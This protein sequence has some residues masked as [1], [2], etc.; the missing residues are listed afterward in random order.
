MTTFGLDYSGTVPSL[1]SMLSAG[2]EFVVRYIGY[3]S[4]FDDTN[5][6]TPQGKCLTKTEAQL[7][8]E[9]GISV[10]SNFEWYA[11]RP[12]EGFLAGISDAQEA[13]KIHLGCGGPPDAPIYFSVD[14]NSNGYDAVDYF[15]GVVSA[16]GI[17][18]VG[19]YGPYTVMQVFVGNGGLASFYWQT[20][21]WSGGQWFPNNDIEQYANGQTLA[22]VEVDYD[23]ALTSYYGQWRPTVFMEQQF[24]DVWY[25]PAS[26][27]SA[28][29]QSGIY[30]AVKAGFMAV[31][32]TACYPIM[33]EIRTK[34]WVGD[35]IVWQS[36]SNGCHAE[37]DGAGVTRIYGPTG[38]LLFQL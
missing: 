4:G 33:K 10:V 5:F 28:D 22:G 26:G 18:R 16:L 7:L 14:Y 13:N 21:A 38:G 17:S 1:T 29:Y 8:S 12:L 27:V 35:D 11:N 36:L 3:F 37:Y 19:V 15:K 34:N 24:N 9:A 6:I 31:K 32:Y 2:V 20:Y 25:N 23:R 30:R